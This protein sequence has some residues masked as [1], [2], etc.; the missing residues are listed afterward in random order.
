VGSDAGLLKSTDAGA[1]WQR[2]GPGIASSRVSSITVDPY[3][4]GRAYAALD[5]G[6]V[7]EQ[8]RGRWHTVNHGLTNVGVH[9]VS[10]DPQHRGVLYAATDRG[11]FKT[12][13][14]GREWRRVAH[15]IGGAGAVEATASATVYARDD[16]AGLWKSVDAGA[17][18][19]QVGNLFN[20]DDDH[21]ALVID[22]FDTNNVYVADRFGVVKTTDGGM[23]WNRA[24]LPHTEVNALAVDSDDTVYAG[25]ERGLFTS[26]DEGQTWQRMLG[27]PAHAHVTDVAT[28][29]SRARTLYAATPNRVLWSTNGGRSWHGLHAALPPRAFTT[30]A[31]SPFG[32]IY[33]G[34]Y[35]GGG[36]IQLQ[37]P[38]PGRQP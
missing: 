5:G 8:V 7:V 2:L 6:G 12:S 24:G 15:R 18:W 36:I 31:A 19:R 22:P 10:A 35:N 25:T 33:A 20:T 14:G 11:V 4:P 29:P 9:D 34:S 38:R 37:P 1:S 32:M 17:S 16:G 27:K 21:Q 13:N 26:I 3:H 28:D 30:L 23:T